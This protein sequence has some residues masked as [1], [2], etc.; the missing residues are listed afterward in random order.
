MGSFYGSRKA[1][2][3]QGIKEAREHFPFPDRG[4]GS[5][6]DPGVSPWEQAGGGNLGGICLN[7]GLQLKMGFGILVLKG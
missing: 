6:E 5:P 4:K 3:K 2:P 1:A 7:L